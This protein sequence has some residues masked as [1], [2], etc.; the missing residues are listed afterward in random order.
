[1]KMIIAVAAGG[2]I[3]ATGRYLVAVGVGRWIGH[4]FPYGTLLVNILGSFALGALIEFLALHWSPSQEVRAFLVVGII[5]AFTTFSTFSLNVV[6]LMERG[7]MAAATG[8]I[9]ASV[10]LSIGGFV[11]GMILLRAVSS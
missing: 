6:T 11:G 3:G 4:G 8:Y 1:M 7:A 10:V 2:A 9:A 5:G